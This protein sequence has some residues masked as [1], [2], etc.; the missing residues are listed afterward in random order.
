MKL[1]I[2]LHPFLAMGGGELYT[3][4]LWRAMADEDSK[5]RLAVPLVASPDRMG[6]ETVLLVYSLSDGR[7]I[8]VQAMSLG[9]LLME[10]MPE[11]THLWVHQFAASTVIY[12]LCFSVPPQTK[13][14]LTNLGYEL[15]LDEF[16]QMCGQ[17]PNLQAL[18]ISAYSSGRSH[19]AGLRSS[20]VTAGIW[21]DELH[22]TDT[23]RKTHDFVAV[24]RCLPHK[25]F[26]I[27]VQ[28]LPRDLSLTVVG[29][30]ELDV[31]YSAFLREAACGRNVTFAGS[32]DHQEKKSLLM[33]SRFLVASS[34]HHAYDGKVYT[35]VELLG[36]VIFEALAHRTLPITSDIPSFSEVMKA[37]ELDDLI[38][39]EGDVQALK[40]LMLQS[41]KMSDDEYRERLERALLRVTEQFLWDD[42]PQ[43]F[44]KVTLEPIH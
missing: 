6:E 25:G 5:W 8:T 2:S 35:Q 44:R 38:Y 30:L 41:A 16:S 4:A 14:Y 18:E 42:Y 10:I 21:R 36:L 22:Y 39:S 34:T 24:G 19:S 32:L 12:D 40:K 7:Q 15:L 37:L 29:N 20:V 27:T 3:A 13:V 33:A 43:R 28:A 23:I 9:Q 26:D 17:L 31:A 11:L 1:I